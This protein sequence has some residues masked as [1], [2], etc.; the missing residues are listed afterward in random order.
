MF[1]TRIISLVENRKALAGFSQRGG[2]TYICTVPDLHFTAS[3][4]TYVTNTNLEKEMEI[5]SAC[6]PLLI[7]YND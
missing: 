2:V 4:I 3:Y 5:I 7:I 1:F 6:I